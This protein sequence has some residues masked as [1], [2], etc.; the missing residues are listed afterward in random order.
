M[1]IRDRCS[2]L[3]KAVISLGLKQPVRVEAC[4]LELVVHICGE[5]KIVSISEDVYK[6]QGR[7]GPG[8]DVL[9]A[10]VSGAVPDFVCCSEKRAI[11]GAG[12]GFAAGVCPSH[13]DAGRVFPKVG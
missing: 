5:D 10:A 4:K 7:D 2:T 1:C 3:P 11:P 8:A 13:S 6:R 12:F 9:P